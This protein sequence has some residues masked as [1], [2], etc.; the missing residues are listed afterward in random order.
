MHIRI[1]KSLRTR[2]AFAALLASPV[3]LYAGFGSDEFDESTTTS[4]DDTLDWP[5]VSF[6]ASEQRGS[7]FQSGEQFTYRAQWGIFRK[8][9]KIK[10]STDQ[11]ADETG[12]T[13]LFS[14]KLDTRSDGLIRRIYPLTLISNTTLDAEN[15][16]IIRDEV[17]EK[18]RSKTSRTLALFD[19]EENIVDYSDE[20][21]P[22]RN[23][24]RQIPYDVALDYA[25]FILQMRGWE[26][27]I[28][29]RYSSCVSTR[30]KFYFVEMQA[31]EV[32]T[33]KTEFG[34]IDCIRVE[35]VQVY[36]ES[37][38]LREGGKMAVWYTA[39]DDRVP[40]RFDV[41]TSVGTASIR[42]EDFTLAQP[43]N[44]AQR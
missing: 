10:V 11:L 19:Y 12:D 42:L 26:M 16:R 22:E 31:M 41:K 7:G 43:E 17:D 14:V 21:D 35:P 33:I 1:S 38:T 37:K 8:A 5:E 15:W 13:P 32:E 36:P 23:K 40:V 39:D 6:P 4:E 34:K 44:L 18:V 20:E 24:T 25:S 2:L 3:I 9:G 29:E 28:G 30:G 27:N